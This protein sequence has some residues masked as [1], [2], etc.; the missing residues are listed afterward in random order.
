M[1]SLVIALCVLMAYPPAFAVSKKKPKPITHYAAIGMSNQLGELQTV[2]D[3]IRFVE[4][5]VPPAEM[6]KVRKFLARVGVNESD[7]LPRFKLNKNTLSYKNLKIAFV[8]DAIA[9]NGKRYAIVDKP[10]DQYVKE[11]CQQL[12]CDKRRGARLDSLLIHEAEAFWGIV[13]GIV[14]GFVLG[15]TAR[16][17]FWEEKDNGRSRFRNWWNDFWDGD[18]RYMNA[19]LT[20]EFTRRSDNRRYVCAD[21]KLYVESRNGESLTFF[22][23]DGNKVEVSPAVRRRMKPGRCEEQRRRLN[24]QI[25]DNRRNQ[26]TED[27]ARDLYEN[28]SRAIKSIDS[29]TPPPK[30]GK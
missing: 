10:F 19:V 17:L 27:A 22:D 29:G 11:V 16:W 23:E 24:A 12:K 2:N 1:R 26:A 7:Y 14:G 13:A 4:R 20:G 3:L 30:K 6:K 5:D 15:W 8:K 21:G 9:I 25:A 28:E 18:N